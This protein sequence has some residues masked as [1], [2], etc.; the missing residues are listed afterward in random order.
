MDHKSNSGED[1]DPT[2]AMIYMID[3]TIIHL[4]G[5]RTECVLS[6]ELTQMEIRSVETKLIRLFGEQSIQRQIALSNKDFS[7]PPPQLLKW[8]NVVG[9]KESLI[10]VIIVFFNFILKVSNFY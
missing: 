5:L 2:S 7:V 3:I 10:K 8:L 6:E 9:L 4:N 1:Y